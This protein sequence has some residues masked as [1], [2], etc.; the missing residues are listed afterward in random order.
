MN[1]LVIGNGFDLAHG[2]P[3]RYIDFLE[4][5]KAEY[6][7]YIEDCE[8][9]GI[10]SNVVKVDWAIKTFPSKMTIEVIINEY[11]QMEIWKCI[12]NNFWIDYFLNKTEYLD[13]NWIDFE[14][15]ISKIIQSVDTDMQGKSF[16]ELINELS[17]EYLKEK[18][19]YK[20]HEALFEDEKGKRGGKQDITYK[21][22]RDELLDDLNKLIRAL[23]IYLCEYVEK[24]VIQKKSPDIEALKIDGILSFNYTNTYEKYTMILKVRNMIIY[25]EKQI[26]II[27]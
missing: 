24:V 22:I 14:S 7:L 1:I 26:L 10:V 16:E 23:E 25:M 27:Q 15:E 3:T 2:L 6:T 21:E 17:N 13:E 4:W 12:S 20:G 9:K 11:I 19:L 5:V 18:Y 8:N